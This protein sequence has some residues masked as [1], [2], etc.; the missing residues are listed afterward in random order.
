M[1]L[2]SL[3]IRRARPD[4]IVGGNEPTVAQE[5]MRGVR[6]PDLAELIAYNKQACAHSRVEGALVG[7]EAAQ[8]AFGKFD[9]WE[10][11]CPDCDRLVLGVP[12][13]ETVRLRQ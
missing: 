11:V 13:P 6:P 5:L 12:S 9:V 1:T 4:F 8:A 2:G 3:F 7:A 10:A